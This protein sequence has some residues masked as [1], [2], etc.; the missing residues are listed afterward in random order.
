MLLKADKHY[1]TKAVEKASIKEPRISAKFDFFHIFFQF[2]MN[3][4]RFIC[5]TVHDL[6]IVNGGSCNII[7]LK[8]FLTNCGRMISSIFVR[9][10]HMKRGLY[11]LHHKK[12]DEGCSKVKAKV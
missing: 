1:I 8:V 9:S 5:Q 7:W 4:R 3:S 11:G 6:T 10:S 2:T 12:P